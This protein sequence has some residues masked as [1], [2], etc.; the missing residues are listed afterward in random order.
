MRAI[1]SEVLY[2]LPVT[3]ITVASSAPMMPS[4]A[5]FLVTATVVPT[6]RFREHPFRAGQQADPLEDLAVRRGRPRAARVAH[7]PEHVKPVGRIADRDGLGERVRL[8]RLRMIE[9]PPR[10]HG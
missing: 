9:A 8:D 5:S 1:A 3:Q 2:P 6:C 7:G 4:R 10:A